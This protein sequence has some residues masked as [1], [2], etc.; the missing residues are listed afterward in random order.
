MYSVFNNQWNYKM[1]IKA[2]P[3]SIE[4]LVL[5]LYSAMTQNNKTFV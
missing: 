2:A 1:E 4:T 5:F 3:Q